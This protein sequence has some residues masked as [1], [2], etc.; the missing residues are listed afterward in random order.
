MEIVNAGLYVQIN[1]LEPKAQAKIWS[2]ILS[3]ITDPSWSE[4]KC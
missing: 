2:Q 3:Q 4:Q 1:N